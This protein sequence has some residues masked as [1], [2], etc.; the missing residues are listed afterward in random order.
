MSIF[1]PHVFRPSA[2]FMGA[3]QHWDLR[4][5]RAAVLGLPFDCGTHPRR[6]GAR[7]GPTAIREQSLLLDRHMPPFSAV[8]AIDALHLV[9]CGDAAAAPGRIAES[10]EII[11][12]AVHRIAGAGVACVAMGGDGAVTL[13]QLR[14]WHRVHPN[15]AVIHVDA[16]TDAYPAPGPGVHTTATT[17][18]YAAEEGLVDPARSFHIGVRGSTS[19]PDVIERAAGLGYRVVTADDLYRRGFSGVLEE[20]R[21]TIEDRP[22]Y[23]C[24]DMDAFDPSCAPGVCDPAWGGL[25]ARDGLG[26]LEGLAGLDIVAIDVNTVSPPHDVGGMTAHLAATVML[27]GLHLLAK[28][29]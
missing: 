15:L 24:W 12:Q 25:S 22:V 11:E 17:F 27:V 14:A 18:T 20:V 21:G 26:L 2:G 5:V 3:P 1:D 6:I 10:F 13:P 8:D 29:L 16:H 7:Q 9:D 19:I 4:D 28:R 23:L